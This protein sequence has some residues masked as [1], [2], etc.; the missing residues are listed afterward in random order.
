MK[1]ATLAAALLIITAGILLSCTAPKANIY[2]DPTS[3]IFTAVNSEF[4]IA[5]P[6]NPTTGYQ[7]VESY[8]P[9]MVSLISSEY[10]P[11]KQGKEVVG[12]GGMQY[13]KFKALKAGIAR[14]SFTYKRAGDPVIT[15]QKSFSVVIE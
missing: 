5:I 8:D 1:R 6:S 15:D 10:K 13:F 12:A 4:T 3:T 7:W 9:S 14:I 2:S 11:T